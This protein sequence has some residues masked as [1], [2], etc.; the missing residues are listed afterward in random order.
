[1]GQLWEQR[2]RELGLFEFRRDYEPGVR[3]RLKAEFKSLAGP[4]ERVGTV[5]KRT[6]SDTE[7]FLWV[8]WDD[9]RFREERVRP[10]DVEIIEEK[11]GEEE[12]ES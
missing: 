11:N 10:D 1:M 12:S 3:V 4:I 7:L 6:A 8:A 5:K 2:E 9:D